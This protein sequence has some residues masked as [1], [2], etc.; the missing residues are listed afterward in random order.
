MS[1]VAK[2]DRL[3]AWHH[4]EALIDSIGQ[5]HFESELLRFLN[6]SFGVDHCTVFGLDGAMPCEISALSLDG[7]DTAHRHTK[8]Y[9][10]TELWRRDPTMDLARQSNDLDGPMMIS[11]DIGALQDRELREIVYPRVGERLLLCGQSLV[12]RIGLSI[13]RTAGR[14][15]PAL[16][17]F[18]ELQEVGALL[19]SILGKHTH[20]R[21]RLR[22]FH[23][24]LTSLV[25]IYQRVSASDIH[26]PPREAQVCSRLLYGISAVGIALDLGIGEETAITYRKRIYGRLGIGTQRELI[27]WYLS[28]FQKD[29]EDRQVLSQALWPSAG[30]RQGRWQDHSSRA[31]RLRRV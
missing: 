12:G 24:A 11:L 19:L 10:Q 4:L 15:A 27:I 3:R 21:Q 29:G 17:E 9:L 20:A 5:S 30:L 31:L 7:T 22:N 8:L 14:S 25:D 1:N 26:F 16:S 13:L 28:L 2:V 18:G 6:H 23:C